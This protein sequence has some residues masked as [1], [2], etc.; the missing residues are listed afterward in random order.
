MDAS[1]FYTFM[2][3]YKVGVQ[4]TNLLKNNTILDVGYADYHPRYD[5]IETDRTIDV[6]LRANW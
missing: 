4:A 5:W 3:H 6:V 1:L 2:D